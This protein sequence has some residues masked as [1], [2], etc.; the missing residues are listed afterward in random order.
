L[1]SGLVYKIDPKEK[2]KS[3]TNKSHV[4]YI[5]DIILKAEED[6]GVPEVEAHD[7]AGSSQELEVFFEESV[8]GPQE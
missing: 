3:N 1:V 7:D 4:G 2:V 5:V 6:K 8:A